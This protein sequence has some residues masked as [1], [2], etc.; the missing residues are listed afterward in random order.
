MNRI[1]GP[2]IVGP[3]LDAQR[4]DWQLRYEAGGGGGG[5]SSGNLPANRPAP[6]PVRRR[7][8]TRACDMFQTQRNTMHCIVSVEEV[9]AVVGVDAFGCGNR[10]GRSGLCWTKAMGASADWP[11]AHRSPGLVSCFAPSQDTRDDRIRRRSINVLVH[12]K[13]RGELTEARG[14]SLAQTKGWGR[15]SALAPQTPTMDV[16]CLRSDGQVRILLVG[17]SDHQNPRSLQIVDL[18]LRR[19]GSQAIQ[20]EHSTSEPPSSSSLVGARRAR[21]VVKRP[22]SVSTIPTLR[23]S[24]GQ[25]TRARSADPDPDCVFPPRWARSA[26]SRRFREQKWQPRAKPLP[27]QRQH[28]QKRPRASATTGSETEGS[29]ELVVP[30]LTNDLNAKT[31]IE[32]PK[33]D[34]VEHWILEDRWPSEEFEPNPTMS[35][36]QCG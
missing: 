23:R 17:S 2:E 5:G 3:E 21:G 36:E 33:E 7:R 31:P 22:L 13:D 4:R 30:S 8:E 9:R 10:R 11:S 12:I 25:A 27:R 34:L 28:V 35:L 24:Q 6:M 32:R 29:L 1:V 18:V 16:R 19:V 26:S 20:T 14:P 15:A